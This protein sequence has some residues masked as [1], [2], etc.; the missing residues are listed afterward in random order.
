MKIILRKDVQSVGE[1]GDIVEVKD[2]YA[3]NYLFPNK[4]AEIA[5]Q[6]ALENRERNLERI[7]LKAEKIH[8]EALA[9]AEKIESL[10]KIEIEAKAGETGKLFGAITTKKLAEILN[11]KT[12]FDIDRKTLSL[13]KPI[14][15]LGEYELLIKLSSKVSTKLNIVVKASEL[16][17]ESIIE[18]ETIAE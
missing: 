12:G 14:N 9:K 4:V 6:G 7:K 1:A 8:Q 5:T 2:G 18:E 13:N 15:Q 10:E 3:R 16:I 17:K 11:E